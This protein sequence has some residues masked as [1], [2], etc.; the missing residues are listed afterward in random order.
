M[1]NSKTYTIDPYDIEA[2]EYEIKADP[3][4]T[5]M[6]ESIGVASSD[7]VTITFKADI[8]ASEE[9]ALDG[10]AAAHTGEPLD[11][12][13][14][15]VT[16]NNIP[17]VAVYDPEGISESV[18]S[19]DWTDPCSWY[20]GSVRVEGQVLT[21][22]GDG[23]ADLGQFNIIDLYHGRVT[24]EDR[25]QADHGVE[26]IDN[27]N[28]LAIDDDFEIDFEQGLLYLKN[29]APTGTVTASYSYADKSTFALP[30]KAGYAEMKVK[31]AEV[32][33]TDD[34]EMSSDLRFEIY[35]FHPVAQLWVPIFTRIYKSMKD[36][37][38][39]AREGKGMIP[40]ID[41]IKHDILVFPLRYDKKIFL[42]GGTNADATDPMT[43]KHEIRVQCVDDKPLKGEWATITFY[44]E[45]E[46]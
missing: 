3:A 9:T 21:F 25:F 44:T 12:E 43:W 1:M 14:A 17:K 41:N 45:I 39:V 11:E 42:S 24:F 19:H 40:R 20:Q 13:S 2:L 32:Q 29:Y 46:Q 5:T 30:V 7:Q 6:I 38:N 18:P 37:I 31:D 8:G 36:I 26:V 34:I 35:G 22:N 23:V 33:F 15:P 10:V 16:S 4:I 28:P 27:G